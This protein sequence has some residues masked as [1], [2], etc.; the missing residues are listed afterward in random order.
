M[1]DEIV[2]DC[3]VCQD[4]NLVPVE[5]GSKEQ[6]DGKCCIG[7]ELKYDATLCPDPATQCSFGEDIYNNGDAIGTCGQ[8]VN[9]TIEVDTSKETDCQQCNTTTW[10]LENKED[11]SNEQEDGKCCV[12][13]ELKYDAALCPEEICTVLYTTRT[14]NNE[15][16]TCCE[17][18]QILVSSTTNTL[19]YGYSNQVRYGCCPAEKALA[20]EKCCSDDEEPTEN[21][22]CPL[23]NVYSNNGV[24]KCCVE[25]YAYLNQEGGSC[26]GSRNSVTSLS[27][28]VPGKSVQLMW[29]EDVNDDEN[30][31]CEYKMNSYLK[32]RWYNSNNDAIGD[33][34][35]VPSPGCKYHTLEKP[36]GATKIKI[37]PKDGSEHKDAMFNVYIKNYCQN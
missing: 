15:K 26:L 12:A 7:G 29:T 23:E 34:I 2:D 10:T 35:K 5:D 1:N 27:V 33:A 8:C 4:G 3:N 37:T 25:K 19:F 6:E 30:G 13:G 22:C 14:Q 18:E 28:E 24:K 32:Y 11:G 36:A 20:K 31:W 17:P 21:E 16:G 9:G